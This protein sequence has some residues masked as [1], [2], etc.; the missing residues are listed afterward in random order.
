MTFFKT[1]LAVPA[2]ALG[3]TA[4]QADAFVTKRTAPAGPS[5]SYQGQWYTTPDG[6]SYSRAKA[7]GYS[8][9]WVLIINPHHI[10]QPAAGP[11]CATILKTGG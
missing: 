5:E 10:G 6:C 7:P 2:L 3:L 4:T 11:H 1:I 9:M 8:T